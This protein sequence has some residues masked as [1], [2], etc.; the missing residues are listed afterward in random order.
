MLRWLIQALLDEKACRPLS[1]GLDDLGCLHAREAGTKRQPEV[2]LK[3]PHLPS[4]QPSGVF[5]CM[6]RIA[7]WEYQVPQNC[8]PLLV[9]E[10]FFFFEIACM[11]PP[12]FLEAIG[13]REYILNMNMGNLHP[14][15]T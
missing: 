11:T 7:Q 5:L 1:P 4:C 14:A 8:L 10:F 9:H 13:R 12:E 2:H 6:S 15:K 3:I